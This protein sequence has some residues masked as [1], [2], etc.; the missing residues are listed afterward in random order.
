MACAHPNLTI[1]ETLSGT[2]VHNWKDGEYDWSDENI[3]P[4]KIS[5]SCPDCGYTEVFHLGDKLPEK[6]A[7][8]IFEAR[9]FNGGT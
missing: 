8:M 2:A 3:W 1:T 4:D 9:K 7:D 5:L 6:I